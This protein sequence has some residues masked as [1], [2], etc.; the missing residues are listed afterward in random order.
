VNTFRYQSFGISRQNLR[1]KHFN[2]REERPLSAL[3]KLCAR[4]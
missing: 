2:A 4:L 1:G 3:D